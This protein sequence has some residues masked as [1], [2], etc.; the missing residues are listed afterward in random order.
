MGVGIENDKLDD[1]RDQVRN[2]KFSSSVRLGS[3][4]RTL[5]ELSPRRRKLRI[6]LL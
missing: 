1:G 4:D 3:I 6:L 5:Y 2:E